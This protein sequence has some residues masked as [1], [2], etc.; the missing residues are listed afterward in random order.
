MGKRINVYMDDEG[1]ELI[2]QAMKLFPWN[3]KNVSHIIRIAL[4]E[5]VGK[6]EI[7]PEPTEKYCKG[8]NEFKDRRQFSPGEYKKNSGQCRICRRKYT[9]EYRSKQIKEGKRK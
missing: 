1:M 3:K 8:C 9:Q 2:E 6:H 4:K 5:Y 7:E